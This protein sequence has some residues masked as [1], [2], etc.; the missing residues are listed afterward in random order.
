ML[1]QDALIHERAVDWAWEF[2]Q[3]DPLQFYDWFH[4]P[5]SMKK[6]IAEK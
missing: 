3:L 5:Q 2:Q 6:C 4:E 1:G